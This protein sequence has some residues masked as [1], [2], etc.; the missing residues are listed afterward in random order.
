MFINFGDAENL[1][2]QVRLYDAL[3]KEIYSDDADRSR[4][5]PTGQWQSGIYFCE[6]TTISGQRKVIKL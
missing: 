5:I 4:E 1:V 2:K 6:V 3:G